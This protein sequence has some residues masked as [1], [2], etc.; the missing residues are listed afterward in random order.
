MMP[1]HITIS[2]GLH[3]RLL[4]HLFSGRAEQLAFLLATRSDTD[5]E[6]L[7]VSDLYCVPSKGFSVQ[8]AFHLNLGDDV[9]AQMIKWAWNHQASLVEAHSH[10]GPDEAA[11]SPTDLAGLDDFVPHV[12]WRLQGRP[13]AALVFSRTGFDALIWTKSP[14]TP[15][16]LAG[17]KI[18]GG[19]AEQP[20][21][22][23]INAIRG[24]RGTRHS[25][26]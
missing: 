5:A 1:T 26:L 16:E 17:L 2:I 14:T 4:D 24:L 7:C 19:R 6:T 3:K 25:P 23:T 9:R 10:L 20:T 18:I 21:S 12:W 11:F 8:T 15:Q 22:I 13:Y